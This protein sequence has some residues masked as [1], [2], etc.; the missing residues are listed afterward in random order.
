MP[1]ISELTRSRTIG[2]EPGRPSHWSRSSRVR[3]IGTVDLA[4]H[5]H[6]VTGVAGVGGHRLRLALDDGLEGII[7]ASGWEWRG[8]F[9][10]L[11]D[12]KYCARVALNEELGAITWPNGADVAPET[13]HLSVAESRARQTA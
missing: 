7:D 5:L 1:R 12:P 3:S 4:E 11:R 13:L 8:V 9:D 6:R 10:E 2:S